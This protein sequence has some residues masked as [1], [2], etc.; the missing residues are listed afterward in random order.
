MEIVVVWFLMLRLVLRLG[1][2]V[3]F[4]GG[5]AVDKVDYH[6]LLGL[7]LLAVV[8]AVAAVVGGLEHCD[9]DMSSSVYLC[10]GCS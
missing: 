1:G 6:G 2:V 4:F 9:M 10:L 7:S 3:L 8:V 5:V